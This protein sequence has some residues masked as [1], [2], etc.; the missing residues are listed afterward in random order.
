LTNGRFGTKNY[1]AKDISDYIEI[2]GT[3][4]AL[5]IINQCKETYA[6]IEQT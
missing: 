1:G 3:T 5:K 6:H 2:N 4:E